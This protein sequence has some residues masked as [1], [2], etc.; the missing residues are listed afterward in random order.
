[1]DYANT[2]LILDII[3]SMNS[4]RTKKASSLRQTST[5]LQFAYICTKEKMRIGCCSTNG[6]SRAF[7]RPES[8]GAGWVPSTQVLG[9]GFSALG[10]FGLY[11][12]VLS[13]CGTLCVCVRQLSVAMRLGL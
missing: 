9:S 13:V 5:N 1:M 4:S 6:F 10:V 7:H 11:T 2:L 3:R 12:G 8:C